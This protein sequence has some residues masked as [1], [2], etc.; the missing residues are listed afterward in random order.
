MKKKSNK[1]VYNKVYREIL[2]SLPVDLWL[3]LVKHNALKRYLNNCTASWVALQDKFHESYDSTMYSHISISFRWCDTKEGSDYWSNL[4]HY[5]YMKETTKTYQESAEEYADS[6]F[7][8]PRKI[9][10]FR[11][12]AIMHEYSPLKDPKANTNITL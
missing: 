9:S 10:L 1:T 5:I 8:S 3:F 4:L 11:M 2:A 12:L 7:D 6:F